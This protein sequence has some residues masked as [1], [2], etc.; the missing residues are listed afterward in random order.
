MYITSKKKGRKWYTEP[1]V[2]NLVNDLEKDITSLN[3]KLKEY[4]S[5]AGPLDRLRNST[6]ESDYDSI[7]D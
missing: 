1:E 4:E 7:S 3:E 6:D 2:Q 5:L